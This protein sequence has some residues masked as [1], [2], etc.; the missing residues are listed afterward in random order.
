MTII[1]TCLYR[2]QSN[3]SEEQL[4]KTWI[5]LS[6][7]FSKSW[8]AFLPFLNTAPWTWYQDLIVSWVFDTVT[9]LIT[10]LPAL[11]DQLEVERC[12]ALTFRVTCLQ[13]PYLVDSGEVSEEALCTTEQG[14]AVRTNHQVSNVSLGAEGIQQQFFPVGQTKRR[15]HHKV[16]LITH[17]EGGD[18]QGLWG[19]VCA[20]GSDVEGGGEREENH[21]RRRGRK[22]KQKEEEKWVCAANRKG[23]SRPPSSSCAPLCIRMWGHNMMWQLLPTELTSGPQ[24]RDHTAYWSKD[25]QSF[26]TLRHTH[27][28]C[29]THKHQML[30]PLSQSW[31]GPIM[32]LKSQLEGTFSQYLILGRTERQRFTNI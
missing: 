8:F 11:T 14:L 16:V 10:I 5:V 13:P 17:Q 27:P 26:S 25:S 32:F 21:V 12:K 20:C 22:T 4:E 29:H 18:G 2:K 9:S 7:I 3:T 31:N 19:L 23:V 30:F 6:S 15:Q 24:Q 1:C 28:K